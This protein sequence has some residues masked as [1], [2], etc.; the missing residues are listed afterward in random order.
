[1]WHLW[2]MLRNRLRLP[3]H[4]RMVRL[5]WLNRMRYPTVLGLPF[6]RTRNMLFEVWIEIYFGHGISTSTAMTVVIA[7]CGIGFGF[8]SF[9]RQIQ[10]R[11]SLG[12]A[13]GWCY[14]CG[15][16]C[17]WRRVS[18]CDHL[19]RDVLV[20]WRLNDRVLTFIPHNCR[21]SVVVVPRGSWLRWCR[22][23]LIVPSSRISAG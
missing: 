3:R 20:N 7:T 19:Y 17:C 23:L 16:W 10:W 8:D 21:M 18:R 12:S 13:R 4:M 1:M 14:R 9:H 15:R 11:F 22:L 2:M 5:R 6:G